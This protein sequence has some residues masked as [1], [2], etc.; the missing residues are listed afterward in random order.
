MA[1]TKHS[2]TDSGLGLQ[3]RVFTRFE[4][5]H[6]RSEAV[7]EPSKY[8]FKIGNQVQIAQTPR[9]PKTLLNE[10]RMAHRIMTLIKRSH[11]PNH[12]WSKS[13]ANEE[14]LFIE[15]KPVPAYEREALLNS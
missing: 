3:V 10:N 5:F 9:P 2:R 15:T 14:N 8:A 11:G 1:N 4:S 12:T 7:Y 6:L 13:Y